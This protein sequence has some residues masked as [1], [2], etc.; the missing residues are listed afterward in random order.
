MRAQVQIMRLSRVLTTISFAFM[1]TSHSAH[2]QPEPKGDPF[3]TFSEYAKGNSD[4]AYE[5]VEAGLAPIPKEIRQALLSNGYSVVITPTQLSAN[6]GLDNVVPGGWSHD[7]NYDNVGG[8]FESSTK[9]ILIPERIQLKTNN[10]PYIPNDE[11][12]AIIR[13][14]IGHAY[15]HYMGHASRAKDFVR[16]HTE[17]K[18]RLRAEDRARFAYFIQPDNAGFSELFAEL[19]AA[20][21]TSKD[22]ERYPGLPQAFPRT[23]AVILRLTPNRPPSASITAPAVEATKPKDGAHETESERQ[24]RLPENE[25]SF[26]YL[27]QLS[28]V[29]LHSRVTTLMAQGKFSQAEPLMAQYVSMLE[30]RYW[31][32]QTSPELLKQTYKSYGGLLLKVHKDVEAKKVFDKAG[33][34]PRRPTSDE[35]QQSMEKSFVKGIV[36]FKFLLSDGR[37]SLNQV[38]PGTP[39]ANA[40]LQQNDQITAINGESLDKDVTKDEVFAKVTGPVGSE[41]TLTIIRGPN[42]EEHTVKLTRVGLKAIDDKYVRRDYVRQR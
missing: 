33:K 20:A 41:L 42:K 7:A 12:P 25:R 17:D 40:G 15:D 29:A 13:H 37:V 39:A 30:Q 31:S 38:F 19:F 21:Y 3:V 18:N 36:G 28:I 9:R 24:A 34:I 32:H 23:T 22:C 16:A 2:C 11:I 26:H 1:L 35:L 6:P 27:P 8:L 5:K 14:E 10:G 4:R